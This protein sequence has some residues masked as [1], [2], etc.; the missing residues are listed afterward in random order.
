MAPRTTAPPG[1]DRRGEG[2]SSPPARGL[3]APFVP[4]PDNLLLALVSL[5]ARKNCIC[6][7][8]TANRAFRIERSFQ[9]SFRVPLTPVRGIEEITAVHMNCTGQAENRIGYRVNDVASERRR[10]PLA[11]RFGAGSLDLSRAAGQTAPEDVVL[12]SR[13]D[14]DDRPH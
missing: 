2:L 9:Q 5:S 13:I 8:K 7:F 12:A 11:Q 4:G 14:T 10:I 1:H 6:F 3:H